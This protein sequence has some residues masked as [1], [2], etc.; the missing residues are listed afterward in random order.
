MFQSWS[1]NLFRDMLKLSLKLGFP[2][3][4]DDGAHA[5]FILLDIPCLEKEIQ[6]LEEHFLLPLS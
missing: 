2:F 5:F 6:W 3:G 1:S 4:S